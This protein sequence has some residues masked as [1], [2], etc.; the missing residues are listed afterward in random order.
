MRKSEGV[1]KWFKQLFN[2]PTKTLVFHNAKFDLEMFLV[3]GIDVLNAKAKIHCTMVMSKVLDSTS[4]WGHG[5][6]TV[7]PKFTGRDDS[8]KL[9]ISKWCRER[10]T[11]KMVAGRGRKLGFQDAP[12]DLVRKRILWDVETTLQLYYFFKPRVE[13]TCPELYE[14]ERNLILVCVDMEAYGV[15]VDISRAK[16]LR[17]DA[18][19]AMREMQAEIDKMALPIRV[20][21]K[22]KGKE[23][24]E[25][26]TNAIKVNSPQHMVGVF[27][28][29]GIE[30]KY[31]SKPKRDKKTGKM[32]GGGNWTFDEYAMVRYVSKPLAVCIRESSEDG[33]SA[34]KYIREVH[35]IVK[36][37]KLDS[38]EL[39]PPL[40]LRLRQLK[41]MVS[42]Y[43]NAIINKAVDVHTE[44][45]GREVGTL[46]CR[47]NQSE[48]MTGRFSAS[49]PN[50]QNIPRILGPRE[51]FIPR[52]GKRN[53][54]ID[55]SQVEMR[56]F[57]HFA[58]DR[59]MAQA[60][61]EDVHEYVAT[62]I[63]RKPREKI[64][65]EQRKRAKAT[66]FGILYGSG[67]A[68]QA[69]TLTKRG[70]PTSEHEAKVI[71][72]SYHREFPLVK[73]L[74]NN[75]KTLLVRQKYVANPFGRRYYIDPKFG[76]KALNYMC[77]GTSADLIKKAMVD[78]WKWLRSKGF[79][80]RLIL[81]VHDEVG[82]E[83]PK[84]EEQHV[85]P[86][87][88]K[89]M[90]RKTQYFVPITVD[91]DVVDTRWSSKKDPVK[92]LGLSWMKK[93]A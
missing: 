16:K 70:L 57:C 5:L 26:I 11:K 52:K 42:T 63:Y 30:L 36:S 78:C 92:D 7:G 65:K 53:W 41:K 37:K 84:S 13:N 46:H 64:T 67:A 81:T 48:A 25:D 31:K 19:A 73:R 4:V 62:K 74:T 91:A 47:F 35:K 90:Q 87:L 77:Q 93:V 66:N 40:V 29:V 24:I 9:G 34:N 27:N 20:T 85:V 50:L 88:I 72:A 51:C 58:Q 82:F 55:Y 2:D 12:D 49:D 17:A 76:Y 80:T 10:N 61:D 89:M 22:K 83:I 38:R 45:S 59:G 14:T 21:R 69:E 54:H 32:K 23:V 44:P 33:W 1:I 18:L 6:E 71:I 39:I 8:D 3:E 43:Y 75:L 56:L 68:T 28:K 15:R 60:I 79:R 86:H